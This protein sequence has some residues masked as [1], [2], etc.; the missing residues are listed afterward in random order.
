MVTLT[1]VTPNGTPSADDGQRALLYQMDTAIQRL[2]QTGRLDGGDQRGVVARL[3]RVLDN[4]FR[5]EHGCAAHHDSVLGMS[6]RRQDGG[7][8]AQ[9][10]HDSA[11]SMHEAAFQ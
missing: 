7:C 6:G 3:R 2:N 8:H 9:R 5:R 1:R 4:V 11:K 10:H